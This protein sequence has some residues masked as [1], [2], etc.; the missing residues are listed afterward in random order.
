[1]VNSNRFAHFEV[2]IMKSTQNNQDSIFRFRTRTLLMAAATLLLLFSDGN[3]ALADSGTWIL[4]PINDDWNTAANWSSN[5][6]PGAE[7]TATFGVSNQTSIT[8]SDASNALEIVFQLGA[9]AYHFTALA[10]K[11]L[12]LYEGGI[13]NQSDV[14]Q[15]LTAQGDN[16]VI[17]VEFGGKVQWAGQFTSEAPRVAGGYNI[18]WI[19]DGSDAGNATFTNK[20]GIVAGAGGGETDFYGGG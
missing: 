13:D 14:V 7:D 9:S 20:G 17:Q 12:V 5:T 1:M 3:N 16:A 6:V 8:F 10:D 15:S 19:L 2:L 4:N 18:V 11:T